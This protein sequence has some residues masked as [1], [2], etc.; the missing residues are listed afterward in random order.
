MVQMVTAKR[1]W[2][3]LIFLTLSWTICLRANEVLAAQQVLGDRLV[4]AI[5]SIPYSQRQLELYLTLKQAIRTEK[6]SPTSTVNANNWKQ[7]LDVFSED[8]MVLQEAVRLGSFGAP[9]QLVDKYNAMLRSKLAHGTTLKNS[10]E[11]LGVDGLSVA[12]TLDNILRVAGYRQNR[13]RQESQNQNVKK[14]SAPGTADKEVKWLEELR[15]RSN[16]RFMAGA[17]GFQEIYPAT[18][19]PREN[20]P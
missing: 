4:V 14:S 15:G 8:M 1:N 17:K 11:R 12:R 5:N 9:D 3:N 6:D 20:S 16:I 18:G 19:G 13:N 10:L 2:L 7:S